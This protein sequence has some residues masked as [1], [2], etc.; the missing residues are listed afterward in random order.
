MMR[1]QRELRLNVDVASIAQLGLGLGQHAGVQPA[2]LC[3]ELRHGEERGLSKAQDL[4]LGIPGRLHQVH[5]VA[6]VAADAVQKVRRVGEVL[7]VPAALVALK[8]ALRV[9][10]GISLER[11]DEL[12]GRGGFRIV[13][14]GGLLGVRMRFART[15]AHL[16]AGDRVRVDWLDHGVLGLTEFLKLSA[17]TGAATFRSGVRCVW[18][19]RDIRRCHGRW[20]GCRRA[21]LPKG[22]CA[23]EQKSSDGLEYSHGLLLGC[24]ERAGPRPSKKYVA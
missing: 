3:G 16:A 19:W 13:T 11:E 18:R 1:R 15:M 7:L 8:T 5:G 21:R 20:L 23:Q 12:G 24:T 9:L 4:A 10:L 2:L 17:V 14:A 6:V 22:H